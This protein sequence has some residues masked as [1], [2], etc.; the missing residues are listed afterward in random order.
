[1]LK[2]VLLIGFVTNA[3]VID[4]SIYCQQV[5]ELNG[6]AVKVNKGGFFDHRIC[7]QNVNDSEL[8]IGKI[9]DETSMFGIRNFEDTTVVSLG[10]WVLVYGEGG[11]FDCLFNT[12]LIDHNELGLGCVNKQELKEDVKQNCVNSTPSCSKMNDKSESSSEKDGVVVLNDGKK[13]KECVSEKKEKLHKQT[14]GSVIGVQEEIEPIVVSEP[15][16][17]PAVA[18]NASVVVNSV[19]TPSVEV[20]VPN[21]SS[22]EVNVPRSLS[23]EESRVNTGSSGIN[24]EIQVRQAVED[25][26]EEIK[27]LKQIVEAFESQN[28]M[29]YCGEHYEVTNSNFEMNCRDYDMETL[30]DINEAIGCFDHLYANIDEFCKSYSNKMTKYL[31]VVKNTLQKRENKATESIKKLEGSELEFQRFNIEYRQLAEQCDKLKNEIENF[32]CM[33]EDLREESY[34][35]KLASMKKNRESVKKKTKEYKQKSIDAVDI[36]NEARREMKK[37][38]QEKEETIAKINGIERDLADVSLCNNELSEFYDSLKSN[39]NHSEVV[40]IMLKDFVLHV[41]RCLFV[42]KNQ[43]CVKMLINEIDTKVFVDYDCNDV[44]IRYTICR[45][46][47][48]E[49][50]YVNIQQMGFIGMCVNADVIKKIN[51]VIL[52]Q[53]INNIE[54]VENGAEDGGVENL[55]KLMFREFIRVLKIKPITQLSFTHS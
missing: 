25:L 47:A 54:I 49:E 39:S 1:M 52:E 9:L 16:V 36:L 44:L 10:I 50:H 19:P 7:V 23:V 2:T 4:G 17:A 38:E 13:E 24:P 14:E 28:R 3:A 41:F 11:W 15:V 8:T 22:V 37:A 26:R 30:T 34:Q 32:E 20:N 53:E 33:P 18:S 6:K 51:D 45:Q 31:A 27:R 42:N 43:Y 55:R 29:N 12:T 21:M 40:S 46:E 35:E 48:Q 5:S